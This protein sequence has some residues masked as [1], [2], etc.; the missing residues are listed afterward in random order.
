MIYGDITEHAQE[1]DAVITYTQMAVGRRPDRIL[2]VSLSER[3]NRLYPLLTFTESLKK[4][5][6]IIAE[7]GYKKIAMMPI[8]FEDESS[9]IQRFI[10]GNDSNLEIDIY[11]NRPLDFITERVDDINDLFN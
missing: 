2:W 3:T 1:Y 11:Y 5:E 9:S 10:N 8:G 6:D 7:K 4:A